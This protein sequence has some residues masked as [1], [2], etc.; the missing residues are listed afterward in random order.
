LPSAKVADLIAQVLAVDKEYRRNAAM[1][2][3]QI[4]NSTLIV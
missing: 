4:E 2:V 1:R 3:V